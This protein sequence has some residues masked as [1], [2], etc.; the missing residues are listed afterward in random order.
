MVNSKFVICKYNLYFQINIMQFVPRE[1]LSIKLLHKRIR[2]KFFHIVNPRFSPQAFHKHYRANCS[3][4]ARCV[5]YSLCAGFAVG[6]FVTAIIVNIICAFL[7]IFYA[8]YPATYRSPA[9][10]IFAKVARIWKYE[11][12]RASC[13]ERV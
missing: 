1:S 3:G 6:G 5:T 8:S 12:G 7:A 10:V 2:I 13:R 11:I 4:Y 9:F